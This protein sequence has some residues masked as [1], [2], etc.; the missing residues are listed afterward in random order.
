MKSSSHARLP[1][2]RHPGGTYF[3][4][5]NL[6]RRH[7]NDLLTRHVKR[8]REAVR[9]VRRAAAQHTLPGISCHPETRFNLAF[10]LFSQ[11]RITCQRHSRRMPKYPAAAL[12]ALTISEPSRNGCQTR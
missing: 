6:L 1:T 8:L 10:F 5:L 11:S 7:D 2:R 9:T 4:T 12:T 3:F